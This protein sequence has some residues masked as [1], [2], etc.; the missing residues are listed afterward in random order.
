MA[1][2]VA[3]GSYL[4]KQRRHLRTLQQDLEIGEAELNQLLT[5]H[6]LE[7]VAMETRQTA[8]SMMIAA[9]EFLIA[10]KPL[11]AKDLD[12]ISFMTDQPPQPLITPGSNRRS[13]LA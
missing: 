12:L 11:Q 4:P 2:I 13:H 8:A 6:K 1:G 9:A 5:R 3:I 7:Y 10:K